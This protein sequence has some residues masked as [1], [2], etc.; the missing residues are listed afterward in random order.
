MK[1][2]RI[3]NLL[4]LLLTITVNGLANALP[5]NGLSTGEVS[6]SFGALFTPAGYVFAIW[7]VIYL[8]LAVFSVYQ[9]LPSQKNNAR[10]DRIGIWF[11]LSNLFNGGWILAWHYLQ[12]P[13]SLL[14][15]LGLLVSLLMIYQRLG[16]GVS[17][18][19]P[20]E[21]WLVDMP[22]S[23][24]L[25][26][27]SVA[28]IANVSVVLLD[29]NWSGFGIS[30]TLWTVLVL[31]VGTILGILMTI[32]RSEVFYPFVLIWA[33]IGITQN[34]SG[35]ETVTITAWAGAIILAVFI[36]LARSILR[37]KQLISRYKR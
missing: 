7:G 28:T 34:G 5:I 6:D 21:R 19:N 9:I 24:Y 20:R 23:I 12:F 10:L 11:I 1:I 33:F 37:R 30:E 4:T 14:I 17:K 36:V 8:T 26:W 27:I 15:M 3:L 2:I 35:D 31:V 32:R 22:F 25:G 18:S 16:I 29:L 13:L